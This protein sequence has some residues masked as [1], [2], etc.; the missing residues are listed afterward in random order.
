MKSTFWCTVFVVVCSLA[1]TTQTGS[2]AQIKVPESWDK[3]AAK[4]DEVVN[5]TLD[6]KTLAFASRFMDDKDDEDVRQMVTN[7][8]GIYVHSLEFRHEG[9]FSDADVEPIRAQLRGPEWTRIVDVHSRIDKENVEIYVKM[10]NDRS[11]GIV[12]LAQ[13]PTELTF[14]HLDGPINPEQIS[15]LS[16]NFGIPKGIR[17][18]P[19]QPEQKPQQKTQQKTQT[20]E[21]PSS[22]PPTKTPPQQ[23]AAITAV[24]P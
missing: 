12:I 18:P 8:N 11:A 24:H 14:V 3:L 6:K 13:E 23:S 7:L 21:Q 22:H 2:T 20:P 1:A 5:V 15:E 17:V 10:V 4:A 19:P 9:E 16:G